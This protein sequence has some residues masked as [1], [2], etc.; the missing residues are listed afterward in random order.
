MIYTILAL[1]SNAFAGA[2]V[3]SFNKISDKGKLFWDAPSAVDSDLSTAWMLPSDADFDTSDNWIQIDGPNEPSKLTQI[4]AITGYA[5]SDET[6]KD[7]LRVKT[8][9]VEVL[10]YNKKMELIM[11]F[12]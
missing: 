2:E 12:Q 11:F 6:F 10:E 4:R 9:K 8:L 5:K 3:S 7:Y 1:M